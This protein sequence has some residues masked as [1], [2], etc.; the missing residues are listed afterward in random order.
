MRADGGRSGLQR[1]VW[2]PCRSGAALGEARRA[3]T[4][5]THASRPHA[6]HDQQEPADELVEPGDVVGRVTKQPGADREPEAAEQCDK[7]SRGRRLAIK[8]ASAPRPNTTATWLGT[9]EWPSA[10][11]RNHGDAAIQALSSSAARTRA[12]DGRE[13]RRGKVD[14]PGDWVPLAEWVPFAELPRAPRSARS[15]RSMIRGGSSSGARKL[16]R[17]GAISRVRTQAA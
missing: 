11:P 5:D 13:R 4:R 16:A 3:Q 17:A 7:R 10:K 9:A 15:S 14:D 2:N 1:A 8:S 6:E 12:V